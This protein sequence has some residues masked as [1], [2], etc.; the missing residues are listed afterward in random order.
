M[1]ELKGAQRPQA[2][3]AV[4]EIKIPGGKKNSSKV[5]W[6]VVSFPKGKR[7]WVHWPAAWTMSWASAMALEFWVVVDL[8]FLDA[9]PRQHCRHPTSM[10]S[11]KGELQDGPEP[12]WG[13]CWVPLFLLPLTWWPLSREGGGGEDQDCHLLRAHCVPGSILNHSNSS[14]YTHLHVEAWRRPREGSIMGIPIS[15]VRKT[16]LEKLGNFLRV[17]LQLSS[18]L[19]LTQASLT[20][21]PKVLPFASGEEDSSWQGTG[22]PVAEWTG[23]MLCS[24]LHPRVA[25]SR[26]ACQSFQFFKRSQEYGFLYETSLS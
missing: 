2:D 13:G 25:N 26:Q 12:G 16:G 11:A 4:G 9:S 15:P 22:R 6:W 14:T 10:C 1:A 5:T 8:L 21:E 7:A 24:Q 18:A 23:S 20:A 3:P 17:P 19:R